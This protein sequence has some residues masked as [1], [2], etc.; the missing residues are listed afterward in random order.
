[1]AKAMSASKLKQVALE[2]QQGGRGKFL[3]IA[4]AHRDGLILWILKAQAIKPPASKPAAGAPTELRQLASQGSTLRTLPKAKESYSQQGH[5][6]ATCAS[7]Q[8]EVSESSELLKHFKEARRH[9]VQAAQRGLSGHDVVLPVKQL[10]QRLRERLP[11]IGSL[12]PRRLLQLTV[13]PPPM[14][15]LEEAV[16]TLAELGALTTKRDETARITVLGRMAIS[17]PLDLRLC[18]LILF[19]VLFG[20]AADAVVMATALSGQD[21]FTMPMSIVIKDLHRTCYYLPTQD[22]LD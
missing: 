11:R 8:A 15:R 12:P 18:R 16:G 2:L 6:C 20:C 17:L 19:G 22:D 7:S 3:P 9:R 4:P 14:E 13:Q 1:M 10:S 21:P 5:A